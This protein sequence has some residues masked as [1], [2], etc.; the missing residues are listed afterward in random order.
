MS[1]D[2]SS[3]NS[4]NIL[5]T[6][7][8]TLPPQ[9]GFWIMLLVNTP[10]TI[11][12]L[13]LIVYIIFNRTQRHA[14]QNH[15][16][17]LIL[18]CGL[19]IQVWDINFYLVFFHYGSVVPPKPVTCLL[20]Y[21]A[22][23]GF[24]TA[25]VILLAWLAIERHILIFHDRWVSNRRGRFLYHYLPLIIILTYVVPY[26]TIVIFFPPC[27][28]TFDYSAAVCGGLACYHAYGFLGMWEFAA[29]ST[30]PV[31]I[32]SIVSTA[33]IL[34]V[35]WQRRRLRQSNQWRKQRRMV[36]QLLLVSSVSI[37]VSLPFYALSILE[38]CGISS[39]TMNEVDFDFFYLTYC[40]YFLFPFA[41]L[42]QFPE[43]R[44]KIKNHIVGLVKKQPR[45]STAVAPIIRG[46]PMN[47]PA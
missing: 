28:N 44:K 21:L 40:I 38:Y 11:C 3:D 5:S 14:L 35:H 12:S 30:T 9:I 13:C 42:C 22:D 17:L 16:I 34:R 20:W 27:E 45:H 33:L 2:N 19:P 39:V 41:S 31:I 1:A 4:S 25:G 26:Y 43:L 24:F 36:I 7:A 8:M 23:D 29:N 15:T 46:L 32:E 47:R 18:L 6:A 10:S 37:S